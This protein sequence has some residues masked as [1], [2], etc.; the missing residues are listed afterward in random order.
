MAVRASTR[1]LPVL[2]AAATF[3]AFIPVLDNGFVNWGDRAELVDNP[4]FKGLAPSNLRWMLTAV[5]MGHY[6]PVTWLCFTVD[7]ALW[8]MRPF[9]Y[10]LTSLLLHVGCALAAYALIRRL[11]RVGSRATPETAAIAAAAG[12]LL[13]ALHPLRVETVA[14]AVERRGVLSALHSLLCVLAYLRFAGPGERPRRWAFYWLSVAAFFLA[15]LAK[16]SVVTLPLALLVLDV[17]PLRR[18]GASPAGRGRLLQGWFDVLREKAPFIVIAAL[19]TI[20][21]VIGAAESGM[22]R[23]W[24]GYGLVPRLVQCAW[25]PAFYLWKTIAPVGLSPLYELSPE[26]NPLSLRVLAAAAVVIAITALAVIAARRVPAIAAA[27]ACWLILLLPVL[28]LV[29]AGHQVAADRY[30]YLP[31]VALSA[32][33]AAGLAA[34]AAHRRAWPA[35]LGAVPAVLAVLAALTWGQARVWSDSRALW[36]HAVRIDP[37]GAVAHNNLGM[38]ELDDGR[39]AAAL[40]EFRTA[41]ACNPVFAEARV[42]L[43][44]MLASQ[45]RLAE[46]VREWEEALRLD[47]ANKAARANLDRARSASGSGP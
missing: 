8:G 27:W 1:L 39:P 2:V 47:P 37:G 46:A 43:G 45:G 9:G 4:H 19:A 38:V 22:R 32:L 15:I 41:V 23:T 28:G 10:H 16:G 6:Q 5:Y 18:V 12:A 7:Y 34:A 20:V 33:A 35:L 36:E 31:A 13:F 3:A 14:W 44:G 21:G 26:M 25:G 42:N 40:E 11:L 24:E 17:Y 30:T 29:Q